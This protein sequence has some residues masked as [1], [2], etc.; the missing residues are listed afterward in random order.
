MLENGGASKISETPW[1]VSWNDLFRSLRPSPEQLN[2]L[3]SIAVQV[4]D[5]LRSVGVQHDKVVRGGAFGKETMIN[6]DSD[7][8]MYVV[9]Q[10][11]SPERYFDDFLKPIQDALVQSKHS[12]FV[13]VEDKGLAV[14]FTFSD[15][16][17]RL[18]AAGELYGGPKDLLLYD[19][20]RRTPKSARSSVNVNESLPTTSAEYP[21]PESRGVH[22]ETTCAIYR[23]ELIRSQPALYK[24]MVRVAKKWRKSCDFMTREDSPGDYLIELLMLEAFHGS[25]AS[26]PSADVFATIFRRFLSIVSSQSGTKSDAIADDSM[27]KCFL[28]WTTYYNQRT[29]DHCISKGLLK[30]SNT[31]SDLCSLVI[32]DPAAPFVNVASTV[33]DWGEVRKWARDSLAHFQNT[34]IIE[35][36]QTRLKTFSEGVEETLQEMKSHL[37]HLQ[38]LEESP[39]RWSGMIQFKDVHFN[40]EGWS[41]VMEVNLRTVTWRLNARKART[42]GMRYSTVLDISLQM[43]GKPLTRSIDVD[44]NFRQSMSNLV[45]DPNTDHVLIA[46]RSEVIRNRDYPIQITIVA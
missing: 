43:V 4:S 15:I 22:V 24:D 12:Q 33:P 37:Q 39:R 46:R 5:V 9:F 2:L 40:S 17:C 21:E 3:E 26:A 34:E 32:V 23:I 27:P 35:V 10:H 25:P 30:T 28:S 20:P 41:A 42:D 36:L 45:F 1:G 11:F 38:E 16:N 29:I 31:R 14:H 19:S 18:F 44:V 7:L 13:N 8:D 6:G